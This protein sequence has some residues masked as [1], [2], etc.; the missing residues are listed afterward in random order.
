MRYVFIRNHREVF[1][2]GLMCQVLG[3]G[4]SGFYAWLQ[5][6]ESPRSRANRRLLVEIKAIH[7]RSRQTYGSPR[8]HADLQAT[9]QACGKHRVAQ[10]R[11]THGIVSRHKRKFKATTN[12]RHTHPVAENVLA[13]Q[14]AVAAPNCWWVSDITYIP[15][16]EGWL[17]LA[18]TL[19]LYHR[20]VVGWAMDRWMTQQL[21]LDAL[22]MALKNGKPGPGLSHHSDQ[23]VQYASKAFQAVLTASGI[24]CSMSRKGNCWDNAVAESFFHTLKVELIHARQYHTRQE[25]RAEIFDYIEVFTTG[26][27]AILFL[28]IRRQLSLKKGLSRLNQVSTKHG[29]VQSDST[30]PTLSLQR[31]GVQRCLMPKEEHE[32]ASDP[33]KSLM[34]LIG[35]RRNRYAGTSLRGQSCGDR[36]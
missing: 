26:S 27:D 28:A 15:T 33:R 1:P 24:Q 7:Q 19:D 14:F 2:V 3:V 10:L 13:R 9:G 16:R 18:I 12:S 31:R 23:G 36:S 29:K 25:A 17:Y 5:R 34:N 8:I 21:V 30:S 4:R 20:K 22:T 32:N 35:K 11:R 6:A